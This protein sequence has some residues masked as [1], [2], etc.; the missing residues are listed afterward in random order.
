[1]EMY[2]GWKKLSHR[3]DL[4]MEMATLRKKPSSRRNYTAIHAVAEHQEKIEIGELA[5]CDIQ[6]TGIT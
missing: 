3:P 1:M 5:A 2:S 4:H 6:A